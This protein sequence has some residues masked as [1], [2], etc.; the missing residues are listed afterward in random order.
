M[1]WVDDRKK[2][3][4]PVV[5]KVCVLCGKEHEDRPFLEHLTPTDQRR[6]LYRTQRY[7]TPEPPVWTGMWREDDWVVWIDGHGRWMVPDAACPIC[8]REKPAHQPICYDCAI[9]EGRVKQAMARG[10]IPGDTEQ[11]NEGS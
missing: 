11:H 8:A 9:D 4:T 7:E 10:I 5:P 2:Q 1:S 6:E 3:T